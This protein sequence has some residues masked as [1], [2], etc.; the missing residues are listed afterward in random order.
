VYL[1]EGLISEEGPGKKAEKKEGD[2][3]R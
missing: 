2:E 3:K 1:S